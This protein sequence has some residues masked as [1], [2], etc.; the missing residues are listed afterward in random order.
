MARLLAEADT[1]KPVELNAMNLAVSRLTKDLG[2][3]GLI[4]LAQPTSEEAADAGEAE[5]ARLLEIEARLNGA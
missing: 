4:D 3:Q 5:L 2:A 1:M